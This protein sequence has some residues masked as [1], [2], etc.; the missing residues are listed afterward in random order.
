MMANVIQLPQY[1][2]YSPRDVDYELPQDWQVTVHN[3]A[4]YNRPAISPDGIRQAVTNPIGMPPLRESARGKKEVAILFD[5]MTRSTRA[6][7]IIPFILEELALAGIED[8]QIR[9]IAAIANHQALDRVSLAKKLGDDIVKRFPVYNHCPFMNCTYVGTTSYGTAAHINSE[10]MNCDL[11]I[12]IGQVLPHVSYGFSGGAKIVMP[13]VAAYDTVT[14]H[15]SKTH[16]AWKDARAK[17]G[18][19]CKGVV[20]ENPI[21]ADA[22]EIAALAGLDMVIDC[23][24]NSR[25]ET[26]SVYAGALTPTYQA[27]VKEAETHYI[28]ENMRDNDIVIA[29]AYIKASE[30]IIAWSAVQSAVSPNGGDVVLIA[31]TPSGG[32]VHYLFE[33]FGKTIAGSA[34]RPHAIPDHINSLVIYSEYP[35]ARS[36]NWFSNCEKVTIIDDWG[37]AMRQLE[38]SHRPDAKVAVYPSADIQYYTE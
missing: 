13:G 11:K 6:Y 3:I 18:L 24:V 8:H 38:K 30:F 16:Q 22:F 4:G 32:V 28:A 10:F 2:W 14:A 12:G 19:S 33:R 1:L 31:N 7:E 35:E 20:R 23:I 9:F 17:S 27:S 25:G 26:V 5:D 34:V 15:H 36:L 21:N 29:N 37:Q